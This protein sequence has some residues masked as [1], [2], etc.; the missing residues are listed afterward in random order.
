MDIKG[1]ID[2][3]TDIV[4]YF[5]TPLTSIARPSRQKSNKE[6][7]GLSDTQDKMDLIDI[8]RPFNPKQQNIHSFQVHLEHFLGQT[9]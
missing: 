2:R 8:Y 5:N 1:E 6:I 9:T 7:A 4:G 3:N